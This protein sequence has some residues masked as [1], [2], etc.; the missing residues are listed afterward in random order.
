[1]LSA[2]VLGRRITVTALPDEMP[3]QTRGGP[4]PARGNGAAG[5]SPHRASLAPWPLVA[6]AWSRAAED[7]VA[8]SAECDRC[9]GSEL[10]LGYA[11]V[12]PWL[13]GPLGRRA[14]RRRLVRPTVW[15]AAPTVLATCGSCLTAPLGAIDAVRTQMRS[16]WG[17]RGYAQGD[18]RA[19][20]ENSICAGSDAEGIL[21][22]ASPSMARRSRNLTWIA[23]PDSAPS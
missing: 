19:P 6:T 11:L 9:T 1:M 17:W 22:R 5:P 20:A 15:G 3:S 2:L 13:V 10:L 12:R 8:S 16:P 18:R 21:L 14:W 23:P 7:G 4:G